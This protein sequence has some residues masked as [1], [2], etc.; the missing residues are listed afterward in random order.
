MSETQIKKLLKPAQ[1]KVLFSNLEMITRSGLPLSEGFDILR[2]NDDDPAEKELIEMLYDAVNEGEPITKVM[3]KSEI[4]PEYACSLISIG[5]K[6][7]RLEETF[8]SLADYYIKRDELSRSIRSSVVYPV[9]MLVMVFVVVAVLLVQV[10]PVF[11]HVFR[12]LG[13][14]MTGI[15]AGLMS[16]GAIL[17]QFGFWIAGIIFAIAVIGIILAVTPSGRKFYNTLF[18]SAP[19]TRDLSLDLSA[20][21][22]SLAMSSML[23]A[24]LEIDTSLEF[25]EK[26]VEDKRAKKSV[27]KI[28][29]TIEGGGSFL[30]AL[31]KS[32]LY[33]KKDM[34]LLS[35]G[36]KTGADA[37]A[38]NQVGEQITIA[39]ES[40]LER[41]I[42]TIEPTLVAIMCVLVGLILLSVMLPL[43][44]ALTGF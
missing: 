37:E 9:S 17:G 23:S 30:E 34:A 32:G 39:T 29:Q 28:R 40:R 14:E 7:G 27:G 21:R 18:Q 44:G 15:S 25:A 42:A 10:M 16:A 6:T 41:L 31:E 11:D 36:I 24:G 38:M 19:I 26:L 22:F 5:E 2:K 43:M 35:I 13:Y 4:V 3:R 20:Q 33:T 1:L 8:A 12:Q